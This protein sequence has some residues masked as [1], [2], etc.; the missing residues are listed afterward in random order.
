MQIWERQLPA[1]VRA[2]PLNLEAMARSYCL[3]PGEISDTAA[4]AK[5]IGRLRKGGL[6]SEEDIRQG[7]DLRTA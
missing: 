1:E 7:I 6:V 4:E 5:S 3:T 2:V